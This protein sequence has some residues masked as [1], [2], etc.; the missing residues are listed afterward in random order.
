M[1]NLKEQTKYAL[2]DSLLDSYN[3]N[4]AL[5]RL[6]GDLCYKERAEHFIGML[7]SDFNQ[8]ETKVECL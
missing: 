8:A 4:M 5:Y 7:K 6:F 1:L 3:E 2:I